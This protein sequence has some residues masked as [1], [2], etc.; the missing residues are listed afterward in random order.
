MWHVSMS[1]SVALCLTTHFM[2]YIR[3]HILRLEVCISK[4]MGFGIMQLLAHTEPVLKV[5]ES[6]II[7]H[8]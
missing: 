6:N 1:V 4:I 2:I 3:T 5:T 7:T 8:L